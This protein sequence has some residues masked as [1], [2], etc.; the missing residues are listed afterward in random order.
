MSSIC[1]TG[2]GCAEAAGTQKIT[3]H[4]QVEKYI[5]AVDHKTAYDIAET[6]AFDEIIWLTRCARSVSLMSKRSQ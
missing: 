3:L 2:C 4:E 1:K 6:L 5:N